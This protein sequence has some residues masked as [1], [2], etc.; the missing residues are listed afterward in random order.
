[1]YSIDPAGQ[2]RRV[3]WRLF[4]GSMIGLGLLLFL[5]LAA[6]ASSHTVFPFFPLFSLVLF[7][8]AMRMLGCAAAWRGD[9]PAVRMPTDDP[10]TL[11]PSE[12]D[13]EKELL[14]ALERHGEITVARAALE[15]SLSVAVAGEMLSGLAEKGHVRVSAE[16]GRLTYAL[17]E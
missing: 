9:P 12:I 8:F 7:F 1:M 16:E 11:P 15:T 2:G 13:K 3:I 4:P 14:E 10:R 6:L 5:V 17:W